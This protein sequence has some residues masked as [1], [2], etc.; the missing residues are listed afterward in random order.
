MSVHTPPA[1]PE[2]MENIATLPTNAPFEVIKP[3]LL[4]IPREERNVNTLKT[5]INDYQTLRDQTVLT[6]IAALYPETK[7]HGPNP[8]VTGRRFLDMKTTGQAHSLTAFFAAIEEWQPQQKSPETEQP[9]K[10][11]EQDGWWTRIMRALKGH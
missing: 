2:Y 10:H 1:R 11:P 7:L 9:E 5:L 4:A 8:A 6:I 3:L